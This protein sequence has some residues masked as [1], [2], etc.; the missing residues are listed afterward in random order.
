MINIANAQQDSCLAVP[1]NPSEEQLNQLITEAATR[2]WNI[3]S[4]I[5][6]YSR[7]NEEI[8]KAALEGLENWEPGPQYIILKNHEEEIAD[9]M[10]RIAGEESISIIIG[11]IVLCNPE[12]N[13][14]IN[15]CSN[16]IGN[17]ANGASQTFSNMESCLEIMRNQLDGKQILY[18]PSRESPP[19]CRDFNTFQFEILDDSG[20]IYKPHLAEINIEVFEDSSSCK[21]KL[22]TM[23][24]YVCNPVS[25]STGHYCTQDPSKCTYYY[26]EVMIGT[27]EECESKA[28]IKDK[29][30]ESLSLNLCQTESGIFYIPYPRDYG[31]FE[32]RERDR[33][34]AKASDFSH[35]INLN[36]E[37][38]FLCG[39]KLKDCYKGDSVGL[40]FV[41]NQ[42]ILE[43]CSERFESESDCI[44]R[45]EELLRI[46]N[47]RICYND[48]KKRLECKKAEDHCYPQLEDEGIFSENE[49]PEKIEDIGDSFVF[50]CQILGNRG[51]EEIC[52]RNFQDC[53]HDRS[54]SLYP[55]AQSCYESIIKFQ[56]VE[57][58]FKD[59]NIW[60]CVS[61][62]RCIAGIPLGELRYFDISGLC[63]QVAKTL[64][65]DVEWIL[66]PQEGVYKCTANYWLFSS[67]CNLQISSLYGDLVSC[68][69]EATNLNKNNGLSWYLCEL[70]K[71]S[72]N[73]F[74][75]ENMN[76]CYFDTSKSYSSLKYFRAFTTEQDCKE[77]ET[78]F[79]NYNWYLCYNE[80]NYNCQLGSDS[81]ED[82]IDS[83]S[84]FW[85]CA[86][87][88]EELQ[89]SSDDSVDILFLPVNWRGSIEE[90]RSYAEIQTEVLLETASLSN[91]DISFFN[92]QT[93]YIEDPELCN[94]PNIQSWDIDNSVIDCINRAGYLGFDF[95]PLKDKIIALTD[96]DMGNTLGFTSSAFPYLNIVKYERKA[97]LTHEL[98]HSTL[99]L[100]DEYAYEAWAR[101]NID[102][103]CPNEYPTC[104]F[105]S[106]RNRGK[107]GLNCYPEDT[108]LEWAEEHLCQ[109]TICDPTNAK[110]CRSVMGPGRFLAEIQNFYE[111]SLEVKYLTWELD[112]R[113]GQV[114]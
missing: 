45:Q 14:P 70:S 47:Y 60:R 33:L 62:K 20:N 72:K 107:K 104:C 24:F 88:L 108:P 89:P 2:I 90:Y 102:R 67:E 12:E 39:E 73:F 63:G 92:L 8:L 21:I 6:K 113:G 80:R 61:D 15:F 71:D 23:I 110:Y 74:C 75:V 82:S 49:C 109:G 78:E 28:E 85:T 84:N 29:S 36:R 9:E 114:V 40:S 68:Q 93:H 58:L 106:P 100:C 91:L 111:N 69:N 16:N 42:N 30:L 22:A 81:C 56:G 11:D 103:V 83:Y 97:T 55:S 112:E 48:G 57:Y 98:G 26:T 10:R 64:N 52:S 77:K 87:R 38:Y 53:L 19:R 65:E 5:P 46:Y 86:N 18:R 4:Q 76:D 94:V 96:E 31:S 43:L 101:Q 95:N 79:N 17:C 44:K 105:D 1:Q 35:V 99:N 7:D 3:Y 13:I 25:V 50:R 37:D 27:E 51:F 34:I 66:Y 59:E 54:I 32:C 41:H